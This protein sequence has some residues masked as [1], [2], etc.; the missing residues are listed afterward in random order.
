MNNSFG[1]NK[2]PYDSTNENSEILRQSNH[3]SSSLI[4]EFQKKLNELDG[5]LNSSQ[6][7]TTEDHLKNNKKIIMQ[8]FK[9]I[10][11]KE[12]GFQKFNNFMKTE[13]SV[14]CGFFLLKAELLELSNLMA[15]LNPN[16]NRFNLPCWKEFTAI[17]W[18]L[19]FRNKLSKKINLLKILFRE[20]LEK[21]EHKMTLLNWK[22]Q[23]PA[24]CEH[25]NENINQDTKCFIKEIFTLLI[26]KFLIYDPNVNS[27]YIDNISKVKMKILLLLILI[28]YENG[29][30]NI[31]TDMPDYYDIFQENWLKKN[32]K[33]LERAY[34]DLKG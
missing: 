19:D 32:V 28:T 23:I 26:D 1:Q 5:N 30:F 27:S 9:S 14:I 12:E 2:T 3:I 8:I 18:F 31:N 11:L 25:F 22:E 24:V 16:K 10:Y 21:V 17:E 20:E 33:E 29:I 34:N 6:V 7:K 13:Y 15:Y 4:D